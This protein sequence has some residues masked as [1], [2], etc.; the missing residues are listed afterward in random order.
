MIEREREREREGEE[1]V[2]TV[3]MH[4]HYVNAK[5]LFILSLPP[6]LSLL[7]HLLFIQLLGWISFP[8]VI[9]PEPIALA[10][11]AVSSPY[12]YYWH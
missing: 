1:N 11:A 5:S 9:D 3:Y 12:R 8:L 10:L 7:P 6:S 2:Y 4:V